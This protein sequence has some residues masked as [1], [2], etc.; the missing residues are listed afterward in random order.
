[1]HPEVQELQ[2]KLK[3]I[4][5]DCAVEV[6]ATKAALYLLTNDGRFELITEYGYRGVIRPLADRT[7]PVVDRCGR[8]R[9]P[10]FINGLNAEPRF[11]HVMFES[12]SDRLLGA[13]VYLR[14][15][16][17]GFIDMR[18]KAGKAPF[19]AA[20][21]PKAQRVAER[22][23]EQF[24]NRN[25]FNQ[26]FITLSE[27]P[28]RE[29]VVPPAEAKEPLS[30][31]A[32]PKP[33]VAAKPSLWGAERSAPSN[34]PALSTLIIEARGNADRIAVPESPETIGEAELAV[35]R[36]L[37][38]SMLLIPGAVVASV[39]AYGHM[40]GV[41][42]LAARSSMTDEAVNVLQ[43]KLN[44]W[45]TK[46][47]DAGGFVRT[48][49]NLPFGTK[50]A[51]ITGALIQKVF[52]APLAAGSLRGLYLTVVFAATPD[53]GAHELLAA[54][55][56]QLQTAIE[57][58]MERGAMQSTRS[59]IADALVEPDFTKYPELRRHTDAVTAR[60][61]TFTRFLSLSPADA[62]T[63]RIVAIVHDAGMRLLEYER[64]Y[65]KKDLSADELSILKE[66][67]A[68]GASIVEPLLGNEIA[69]AVLCH[70]ERWDGTGY[71]NEVHGGD[72]PL[73][74]RIVQICDVYE[75]M[76]AA[77]SY[78]PAEPLEI[79]ASKIARAAGT[80]LDPDLAQ[81]FVDMLRAR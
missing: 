57:H 75:T 48:N 64:L 66:H 36:D 39:S 77:D 25:V 41:Q 2:T 7:D 71:P 11:S 55:H 10:F 18:D 15:H 53:R 68:V 46:R 38:R 58:S 5:Y 33:A 76:I 27:A 32:P 51:Q 34:V 16:M 62:E 35:I 79:A 54:F 74:A 47:G 40:G 28:Q 60:V 14:G 63:A 81:K 61:E 21:L 30:I 59:R 50:D 6:R 70:H 72:I 4:L 19:D 8:G 45:L 49:I 52:T 9:A 69:R 31:P 3:E 20:D 26:R 13:P 23:A 42:E 73:A 22:I 1:M 44:L 80:Q 67:A 78:A 24:A 65:R 43:S 29:T 37:L 12:A 56:K 17:V